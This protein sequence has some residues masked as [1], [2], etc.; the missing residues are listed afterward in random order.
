LL[1]LREKIAGINRKIYWQ[2][3]EKFF[4]GLPEKKALTISHLAQISE[5]VESHCEL[6]LHSIILSI[7][8]R[9]HDVEVNLRLA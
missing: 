9:R 1:L 7:L 4:V 6:L 5:R 3:R 8:L 2:A